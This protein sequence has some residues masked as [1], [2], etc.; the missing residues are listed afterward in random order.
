MTI[1]HLYIDKDVADF[2]LTRQIQSRLNIPAEVVD[3]AESVF[4]AIAGLPDPVSAGKQRLF[5]THNKGAFIRPCPGT[6]CYTCCRYMILHIGTFCLMDCAY[7]ILQSYF[8]PPMLQYYVNQAAMMAALDQAF[9]QRRFR[10]I[11][12]GEFT[13]SLIWESI[14]AISEKLIKKFSTQSQMVLEIK[15]KTT[16]I[17]HLLDLA[18][19]RKTIMAWSLNT[20]TVIKREERRTAGLEARL[21]AAYRCQQAGYPLAFH[22]DPLILYPGCEQEYADVL[23][24]LFTRINPDQIVWISV[25]SFRFMPDLKPIV[26]RRFPDS[27]IIYG[28]FIKGLDGKMRYFKPLRHALYKKFIDDI[29]ARAPDLCVYFCMEDEKTWEHVFGFR[30]ADHGGL[31]AMLDNSAIRHCGLSP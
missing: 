9:A 15:T 3:S 26:A 17:D 7:C 30:P 18:H 6:R 23:D 25:G 31:P 19:N 14:D 21:K 22:F 11:G 4:R 28:E 20:E 27:K 24:R 16:R 10:R 1:K 2:P 5:V 13:D 29:K 8:H 12:T